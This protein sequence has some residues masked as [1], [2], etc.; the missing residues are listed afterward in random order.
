[1]TGTPSAILSRAADLIRDTAAAATANVCPAWTRQAVRHIA[2]N[3]DIDCG[4]EGHE[5]GWDHDGWDRYD[6]APWIALMSPA[7][8]DSQERIL[9][10]SS[11]AWAKAEEAYR[12]DR[13]VINPSPGEM[14]GHW[15]TWGMTL[16]ERVSEADRQALALARAVLGE[17]ED[18]DGR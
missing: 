15:G 9:R 3:C 11:A 16:E 10:A 18:T 8:A 7:V 6:D 2:R 12:R 5:G 4:H 1:M 13:S 14:S 17:K